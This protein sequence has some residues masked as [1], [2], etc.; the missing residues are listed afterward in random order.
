MCEANPLI[1]VSN[2]EDN[3][4]FFP[5][6]VRVSA[7]NAL[8]E[9]PVSGNVTIRSAED[10][11]ARQVLN[12]KCNPYNS[13]AM[14]VTWDM[15]D[16]NDYEVLRGR[17][18]GKPPSCFF[19]LSKR[20]VL[21]C[22]NQVT[23]FGTGVKTS[24][25]FPITGNVIFLANVRVP[26]SLVSRRI[27]SMLF[28]C[29]STLSTATVLRVACFRIERFAYDLSYHRSTFPFASHKERAIDV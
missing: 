14:I 4:F 18:I 8:G 5:Y 7:V 29:K 11:P 24:T 2:R 23:Q 22:S 19:S 28:E 13:T 3:L 20:N 21:L 6:N 27:P 15:I 9:G 16:E 17:L 1:L 10:R 25:S 26:S 12:V